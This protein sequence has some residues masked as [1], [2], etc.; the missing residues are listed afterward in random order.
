MQR[1]RWWA[2]T[3]VAFTLLI[4]TLV[5]PRHAEA[6]MLLVDSKYRV[7]TIDDAGARFSVA[8]PD[9]NPHVPQNWVH[10]EMKTRGYLPNGIE[11]GPEE[12]LHRLRRGEIVKVNGGRRWD[13]KITADTIWF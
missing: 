12:L 5:Q 2:A 3:S 10:V 11:L 13:G 1:N 8:L 6:Q 4:L 9:A 7:V